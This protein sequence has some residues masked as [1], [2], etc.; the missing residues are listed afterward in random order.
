MNT[1][2]GNAETVAFNVYTVRTA[3]AYTLFRVILDISLY[4][5]DKCVGDVL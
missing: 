2:T 4:L 3:L 5:Q 1:E